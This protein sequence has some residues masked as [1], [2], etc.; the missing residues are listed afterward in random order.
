MQAFRTPL[1]TD[2]PSGWGD[3]FSVAPKHGRL[4]GGTYPWSTDVFTPDSS[5]DCELSADRLPDWSVCVEG[6]GPGWRPGLRRPGRSPL[7]E[8]QALAVSRGSGLD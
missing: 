4:L 5:A 8:E 6:H 3:E 2:G 7:P 1:S